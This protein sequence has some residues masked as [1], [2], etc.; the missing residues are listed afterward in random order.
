MSGPGFTVRAAEAADAAGILACLAAAFAPYRDAYTAAA[1][2]DTVPDD[3]GVRQ[4]LQNM[5]LFVAI[6]GG[7]V[8]GT[9]GCQRVDEQ[10]GHLRGMGVLPSWQGKGVADALLRAAIAELRARGC[11]RVTLDTTEPLRRAVR[12]YE[13]HGFAATGRVT[14]FFG[15]PLYE[16]VKSL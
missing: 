6:A 4:R 8:V 5:A 12:F 9:V 2:A 10:E 1:F 11:S 16:Y 13:R 15:M 7:A 14:D 3:A